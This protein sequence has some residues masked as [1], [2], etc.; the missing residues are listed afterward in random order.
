MRDLIK[1]QIQKKVYLKC[2][3]RMLLESIRSRKKYITAT[4][5]GKMEAVCRSWKFKFVMVVK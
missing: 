4:E 3:T 1:S 5:E 2:G